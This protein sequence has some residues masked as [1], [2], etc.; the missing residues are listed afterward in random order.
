MKKL[1]LRRVELDESLLRFMLC[2]CVSEVQKL[3]LNNCNI[4]KHDVEEIVKVLKERKEL[5]KYDFLVDF[6]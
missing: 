3:V 2:H 4:A 1:E 6:K 5:V